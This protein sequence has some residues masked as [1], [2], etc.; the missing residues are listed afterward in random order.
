MAG[1]GV[2]SSTRLAAAALA[3]AAAALLVGC[4]AAGVDASELDA[5][6][7][8]DELTGAPIVYNGPVPSCEEPWGKEFAGM[9][10]ITNDRLAHRVLD[11]CAITDAEYNAISDAY[12]TCLAA[13]GFTAT[14]LGPGEEVTIEN[15]PGAALDTDGIDAG[16]VPAMRACR[17]GLDAVGGLRGRMLRNPEHL[18]ENEIIVACLLEAG[19]V[20]KSYT[21]TDYARELEAQTFSYDHESPKAVECGRDP[22][23]KVPASN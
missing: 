23:G 4:T 3:C 11:D 8:V 15:R 7:A 2:A 12:V 6:G 5:P 9:Y 10:R 19:V 17:S 1:I 13:K 20:D 16:M 14:V 22:L 18:D 21:V